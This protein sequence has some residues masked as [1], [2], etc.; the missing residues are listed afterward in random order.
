M[1]ESG[2]DS[3]KAMLDYV[4]PGVPI[5]GTIQNGQRLLEDTHEM[6][7]RQRWAAIRPG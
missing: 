5:S 6:V 2:R 4:P 1:P 7:L 3:L